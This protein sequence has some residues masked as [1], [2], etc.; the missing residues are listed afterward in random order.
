MPILNWNLLDQLRIAELLTTFLGVLIMFCS[1]D[2]SFMETTSER[3]W[4]RRILS[5]MLF[6]VPS[7]PSNISVADSLRLFNDLSTA[8]ICAM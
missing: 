4:T 1:K 5:V 8:T 6:A 2:A 3:V 7:S